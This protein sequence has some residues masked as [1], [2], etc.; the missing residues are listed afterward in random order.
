[1]EKFIDIMD[2]LLMKII[3]MIIVL[4]TLITIVS[5]F[6]RYF[7]GISYV[8]VEELTLFMFISTTFFGSVLA[9]KRREHLAIDI[10]YRKF[11][12][13]VKRILNIIFDLLILYLYWQI[14]TISMQWINRVGNVVTPGMRVS[15]KYIYIILPLSG[16]LMCLYLVVDI[17]R[18]FKKKDIEG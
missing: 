8:W 11:S 17:Y 18:K 6:L 4:M 16:V 7:F 15:M 2:S 12:A 1:M 13:K 5:V 9:F 10:L 3:M 14:I